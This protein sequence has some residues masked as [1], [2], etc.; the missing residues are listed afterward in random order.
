M[1]VDLTDLFSG[2]GG[3]NVRPLPAPE[4]G[5]EDHP[6]PP[7]KAER[8]T[9]LARLWREGRSERDIAEALDLKIGA[10][11]PY[12]RELRDAGAHFPIAA[13]H[14]ARPR[15]RRVSDAGVAGDRVAGR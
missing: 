10:V 8:D 2:A 15:Q 4:Y 7:T 3:W 13:L 14:G 6:H 5:P 9:L 11:G 1:G 12:V